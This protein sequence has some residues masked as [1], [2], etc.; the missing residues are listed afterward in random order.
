ME[1]ASRTS[2]DISLARFWKNYEEI[3]TRM[4]LNSHSLYKADIRWY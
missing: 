4:L 3:F 1:H 2:A